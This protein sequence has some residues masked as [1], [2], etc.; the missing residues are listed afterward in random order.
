MFRMTEP[1][2]ETHGETWIDCSDCR[3]LSG[4][5]DGPD[6]SEWI[7]SDEEKHLIWLMREKSNQAVDV[8]EFM[9]REDNNK[10][11]HKM[12]HTKKKTNENKR[13]TT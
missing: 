11:E 12:R 2:C 4:F 13:T 7:A 3:E 6:E 9:N 8:S 5:R 1:K 10:D